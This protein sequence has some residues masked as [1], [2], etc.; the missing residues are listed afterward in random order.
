MTHSNLVQLAGRQDQI[1]A[2]ARTRLR[3]NLIT[4]ALCQHLPTE[5]AADAWRI[6]ADLLDQIA[7]LADTSTS[8]LAQFADQCRLIAKVIEEADL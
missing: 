8:A 5:A 7:E 6:K 2:H 4:Q 1:G 3:L